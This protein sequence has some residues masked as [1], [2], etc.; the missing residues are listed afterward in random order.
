M[1]HDQELSMHLWVEAVRTV[2]Y[3]QNKIPHRVLGNKTPEEIFTGENSE[4]IHLR[5]FVYPVYVHVPKD[6]RL[7]L[8]PSVKKRIF[9]W[10]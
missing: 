6:N 10:I 7:E 5:I 2:V 8:D 3:V 9:F 1:I 4:V